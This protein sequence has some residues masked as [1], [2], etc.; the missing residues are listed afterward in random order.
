LTLQRL[1]KIITSSNCKSYFIIP[2][3]F[4]LFIVIDHLYFSGYLF[5]YENE[6]ITGFDDWADF[7]AN[8]SG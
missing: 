6:I 4:R 8:D 5:F 7:V 3:V 1:R 2:P